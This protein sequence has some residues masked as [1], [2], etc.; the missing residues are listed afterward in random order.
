M[1]V[2][3]NSSKFAKDRNI[4]SLLVLE[5]FGFLF[6]PDTY[7][8][9]PVISI[10]IKLSVFS[11]V[12]YAKKSN[13][14]KVIPDQKSCGK[15]P[16]R[17]VQYFFVILLIYIFISGVFTSLK[18]NPTF[19]LFGE[20]TLPINRSRP[21]HMAPRPLIPVINPFNRLEKTLERVHS[22]LNNR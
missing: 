10:S 13:N 1:N 11:E 19:I 21:C 14:L 16:V 2:Q 7:A 9:S 4:S 20:V 22:S 3:M 18:I 15:L 5:I 17:V 12:I 6:C 8:S